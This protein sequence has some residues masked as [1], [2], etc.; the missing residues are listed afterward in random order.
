MSW[1]EG[2]RPNNRFLRSRLAIG[3]LRHQPLSE[4]RPKGVEGISVRGNQVLLLPE[5]GPSRLF[6]FRL[7]R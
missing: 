2:T 1:R 4:P 5:D 3:A 7:G 6:V